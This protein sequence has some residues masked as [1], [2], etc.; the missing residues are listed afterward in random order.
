MQADIQTVS[1]LDPHCFTQL[2]LLSAAFGFT[3]DSIPNKNIE[4]KNNSISTIG[5]PNKI[6][7][8][9]GH[10]IHVNMRITP[11]G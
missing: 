4:K 7:T 6:F 11:T 10:F 1:T 3:A 9:I 5:N 8:H 2:A